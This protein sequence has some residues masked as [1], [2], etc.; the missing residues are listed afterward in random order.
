MANCL[1]CNS[2]I[3]I[4]KRGDKYKKFCNTKCSSTYNNL[5]RKPPTEEQKKKIS[6]SLKKRYASENPPKVLSPSD[7]SKAVGNATKNKY[8]GLSIKSIWDCS[9]RTIQKILKR[10]GASCAR[11]GW[12]E[13]TCDIHHIAGRKI[14]DPHNH[15]NLI[16]LCPNC[17]R[18]AHCNKIDVSQYKTIHDMFGEDWKQHY[19][20]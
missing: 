8:Q 1:H 14:N 20:G 7:Q 3:L 2:E 13:A 15:K 11:C 19:Y 18:L 5:R 6:E 16:I 10:I 9:S 17:H 12:N 4:L